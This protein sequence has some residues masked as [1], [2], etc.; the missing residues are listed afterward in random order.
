MCGKDDRAQRRASVNGQRRRA[1][2]ASRVD[3]LLCAGACVCAFVSEFTGIYGH[4][5]RVHVLSFSLPG[6]S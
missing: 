3:G 4:A 6:Y 5:S 2:S 1:V